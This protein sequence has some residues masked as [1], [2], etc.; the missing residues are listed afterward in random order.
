MPR[1]VESQIDPSKPR[2]SQISSEEKE[3]AL[4]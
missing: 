2:V 1:F 4:T 3:R